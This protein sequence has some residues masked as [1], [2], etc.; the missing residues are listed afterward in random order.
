VGLVDLLARH[1]SSEPPEV[2]RLLEARRRIA[3]SGEP[4]EF[5]RPEAV[6]E[7]LLSVGFR[8]VSI[9]ARPQR[10]VYRSPEA[11]VAYATAWGDNEREWAAMSRATREAVLREFS[12]RTAPVL[13]DEGLVVEVEYYFC[14][15]GK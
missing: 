12:E 2:R 1:R 8:D 14:L 3:E 7:K 13:T 4:A 5:R 11:Y 6:R 15:A 9:T 10:R